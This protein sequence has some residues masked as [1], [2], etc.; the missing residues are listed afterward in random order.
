[1][2]E[3]PLVPL[4]ARKTPMKLMAASL[5]FTTFFISTIFT[6]LHVIIITTNLV[7][8]L[9]PELVKVRAFSISL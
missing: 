9:P 8:I 7:L 1:M 3:D 6:F 5:H 2:E 4:K